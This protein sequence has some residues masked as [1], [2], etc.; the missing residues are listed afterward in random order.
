MGAL[1]AIAGIL[2]LTGRNYVASVCLMLV[3][4][5]MMVSKDNIKIN[6]AVAAITREATMRPENLCRDASLL[7]VALIILGG[8]G[9]DNST[10]VY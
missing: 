2:L 8:M 10:N 6:S 9:C 7:G 3:S 5:V 4:I 1:T